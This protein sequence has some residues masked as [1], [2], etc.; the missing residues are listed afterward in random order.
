MTYANVIIT[1]KN[2]LLFGLLHMLQ[3]KQQTLLKILQF[4]VHH[5]QPIQSQRRSHRILKNPRTEVQSLIV[6]DR[7]TEVLLFLVQRTKAESHMSFFLDVS[8]L[9][10]Y[11]CSNFHVFEVAGLR[12]GQAGSPGALGVEAADEA[13]RGLNVDLL[14]EEDLKLFDLVFELGLSDLREGVWG[15][16]FEIAFDVLELVLLVVF[17]FVF[18]HFDV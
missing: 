12:G 13:F 1:R 16:H 5:P 14:V 10:T 4:M 6:L 17:E 9:Y 15:L 3:M 8:G 7:S 2:I 18:E 11:G